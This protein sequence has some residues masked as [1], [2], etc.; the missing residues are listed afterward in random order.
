M[1]LSW[2]S[3]QGNIYLSSYLSRFFKFIWTANLCSTDLEKKENTSSI[4]SKV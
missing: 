3:F 1:Y 2:S 4:N